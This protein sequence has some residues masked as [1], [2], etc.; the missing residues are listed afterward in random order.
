MVENAA[1]KLL[2][3]PPQFKRSSTFTNNP[4]IS[5][6]AVHIGSN[7]SLDLRNGSLSGNKATQKGGAVYVADATITLGFITVNGNTAQNGGGV[8]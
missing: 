1:Y 3:V 5:G 4:S 8:L 2:Y 7:S 6:A